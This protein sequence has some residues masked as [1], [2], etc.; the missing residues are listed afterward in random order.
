MDKAEKTDCGAN[1]EII[2]HTKSPLLPESSKIGA[3]ISLRIGLRG[4]RK[5]V[6]Y[7]MIHVENSDLS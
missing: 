7:P 5:E 3:P 4:A 2:L 6:R 1:G